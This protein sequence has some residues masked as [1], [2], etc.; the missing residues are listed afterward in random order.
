MSV[1]SISF[2]IVNVYSTQST[3]RSLSSATVRAA[4]RPAA[5]D[6]SAGDQRRVGKRNPLVDAMMTA[7][8]ELGLTGTTA[9]KAPAAI[10]AATTA[11]GSTDA[12]AAVSPAPAPFTSGTTTAAA[13]SSDSTT[14]NAPTATTSSDAQSNSETLPQAVAQFAHALWSALGGIGTSRPSDADR[15]DSGHGHRHHH[16]HRSQHGY[17]GLAQRLESL[18]T[19]ND[20]A[21][22]TTDS[23]SPATTSA[24]SPSDATG[25]SAQANATAATPSASTNP[26]ADAFGKLLTALRGG[27]AASDADNATQL[28]RFLNAVAHALQPS[29][30]EATPA[31]KGSLIDVT[32]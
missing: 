23:T 12:A 29:A 17:D 16:A 5:D 27:P 24:S 31:A 14:S 19:A 11:V 15:G 32:A 2:T 3:G 21:S 13:S 8:Q 20:P 26:L 22:T 7:L 18:A 25:V 10:V 1:A 28:S 6:D 4:P 30:A 9:A